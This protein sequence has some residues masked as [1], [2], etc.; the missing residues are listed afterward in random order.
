MKKPNKKEFTESEGDAL[1]RL[2]MPAYIPLV[3][4]LGCLA[5]FP[6]GS[7]A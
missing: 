5:M 4:G 6:S 1:V 7:H 3:R 2:A